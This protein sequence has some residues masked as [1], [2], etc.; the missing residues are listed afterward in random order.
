MNIGD[1]I[2]GDVNLNMKHRA[3][4]YIK[5]TITKDLGD[6]FELDVA[7]NNDWTLSQLE[8]NYAHH[9]KKILSEY[10]TF[11]LEAKR[12][13]YM[14]RTPQ[15]FLICPKEFIRP[16]RVIVYEKEWF[17]PTHIKETNLLKEI[18][19]YGCGRTQG[20]RFQSDGEFGFLQDTF[21]KLMRGEL[22]ENEYHHGR[23]KK[24]TYRTKMYFTPETIE[25]HQKKEN[26]DR[27]S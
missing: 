7:D 1:E 12:T 10:K 3:T 22:E 21:D 25:F 9:D 13:G 19:Y 23:A 27:Y 24:L 16:T 4:L 15:A 5:G 6:K 2:R 26:H 18:G 11:S 14:V 8:K 20:Y 17:S